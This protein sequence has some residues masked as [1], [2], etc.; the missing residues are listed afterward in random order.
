MK[1][2]KKFF[3]ACM[4]LVLLALL[5]SACSS[6]GSSGSSS[7]LTVLQVLQNS[8]KAMQQLKS[9]HIDFSLTGSVQSSGTATPTSSTSPSS[10]NFSVKGSGDEALP[11]QESLHITTAQ[12]TNLAEIVLGNKV[13]IQNTKGQWYVL[14]KSSLQGITGNPFSGIDVS[15]MNDILAL[16]QHAQITDHGDQNLNGQSLRHITIALDKQGLQQLLTQNGQLASVIGQQAVNA[17]INGTQGFNS[18]LDIWIDETHFY[19]HRTELKLNVN[20][21]LSVATATTGGNVPA[22]VSTTIDSIVDLSKFNEPVTI[23]APA[24]AI[25][26]TNP[27][28]IFTGQ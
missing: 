24:N 26:T 12:G 23:T 7:N 22:N 5:I 13:Y 27:V 18:T 10:V 6:T 4:P 9:S 16:A 14:D 1:I 28:S 8:A 19:V 3:L 11:N 25:P 20:A 2:Q 17:I 21:N 15:N